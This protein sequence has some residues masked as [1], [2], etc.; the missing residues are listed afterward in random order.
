MREIIQID[1]GPSNAPLRDCFGEVIAVKKWLEKGMSFV[2]MKPFLT[3][4]LVKLQK[5]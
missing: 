5:Y 1:Q 4:V 3:L 2:R